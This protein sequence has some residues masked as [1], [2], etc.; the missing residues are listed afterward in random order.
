MSAAAGA[1]VTTDWLNFAVAKGDSLMVIFDAGSTG[2]P[3]FESASIT[4]GDRYF[5]SASASFSS[6]TVSG[7]TATTNS[8]VGVALIEAQFAI[9][10]TAGSFSVTGVSTT[11]T[12]DQ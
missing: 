10:A 1:S 2:T 3:S 7:Y 4:N 9:D 11:Q 8:D 6:A 12:L 5:K